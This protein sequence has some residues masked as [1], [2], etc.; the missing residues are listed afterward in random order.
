VAQRQGP[1]LPVEIHYKVKK[2]SS[3]RIKDGKIV[4][5]ISSRLPRA[6]QQAHIESL[7]ERLQARQR[8][9]PPPP[10]ELPPGSVWTDAELAARA[11][12]INA[13][14]YGFEYD[15]IRFKRQT[16]RW[17]SCS[18]RTRRIYV[19]ERLRGGPDELL[20]Y[21]II[22]E[23]CHLRESGHGPRFWALVAKACPDYRERRRRLHAWG[24]RFL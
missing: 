15:S 17:G 8:K 22:H 10:L 11:A 7:V 3:G 1:G 14:H 18:L 9:P 4:L 23:L 16:S 21:L 13:E 6:V 12:V 19:S 5:Y 24:R 20:D 2:H